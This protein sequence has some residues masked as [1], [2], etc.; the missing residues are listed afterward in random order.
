MDSMALGQRVLAEKFSSTLDYL[1]GASV[2]S[3]IEMNKVSFEL[4]KRGK[5]RRAFLSQELIATVRSDGG[6]ALTVAGAKLLAKNPAFETNCVRIIKDEEIEELVRR[7]RSVFSAHVSYCGASIRANS[8]VV[9]LDH[10]GAVLAVGKA[11]L[12]SQLMLK[13]SRGV[14]VKVRAGVSS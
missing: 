7:G 2:S 4:S 14:G 11:T 8:E 1:F 10:M 3:S 6:I 5:M 9:V 13:I 12:P